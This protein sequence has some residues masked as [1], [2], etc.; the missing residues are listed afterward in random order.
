VA[1]QP[2][3]MLQVGW[4]EDKGGRLQLESYQVEMRKSG[5]WLFGNIKARE[6]PAPYLWGLVK[7]EPGQIIIWTPE[8]EHFKKLVQSG[9]LPG[10]V[11]QGGDLVLEKLTP[12][13]LKLL[14]SETR[15][16]PFD[17]KKPLVFFR[18]GK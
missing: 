6:G 15:G 5:E 9:A 10:K 12:E 8:Q 17:W 16:V 14:M 2:Q 11:D 7:L 18:T 1:D 13:H 4:V 3:G